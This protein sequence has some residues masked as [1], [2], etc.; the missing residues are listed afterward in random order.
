MKASL[1]MWHSMCHREAARHRFQASTRMALEED[2]N[3][4]LTCAITIP[5]VLNDVFIGLGD[6]QMS[7]TPH[8]RSIELA[9][10]SSS[11]ELSG[12][13]Y[14]PR[15]Q[16]YDSSEKKKTLYLLLNY[17]NS[18]PKSGLGLS[19]RETT[20]SEWSGT[21]HMNLSKFIPATISTASCLN[22]VLGL[23]QLDGPLP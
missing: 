10:L 17:N 3:H 20:Q 18:L 11:Q 2:Y 13:T 1:D 8:Q 9:M 15:Q 6:I 16:P 21:K 7:T 12:Q 19:E 5:V 22:V 14:I 23:E 4:D